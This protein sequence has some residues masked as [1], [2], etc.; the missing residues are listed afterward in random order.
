MIARLRQEAG[1][2]L[3]EVLVAS[4]LMVVVTGA[5]LSVLEGFVRLTGTN[6]ARNDSQE[7]AR[8]ASERLNRELRNLASPTNA[9][10]QAVELAESDDLVFQSVGA[11]RPAGSTNARNTQRVRYCLRPATRE[12]WRAAQTWTGPTAPPLPDTGECPGGWPNATVASPHVTN[13]SGRALWRYNAADREDIT[14][15]RTDLYVD[16]DT[17]RP[18][19][20]TRLQSGVF[21]RNQNRRPTASFTAVLQGG[22]VLLNASDSLDPEG[23]QL[24]YDWTI[25]GTARAAQGVTTRLAVAPGSTHTFALTVTDPAFLS[26]T[27]APR[28]VAVPPAS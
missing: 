1:V 5:S 6:E 23:E 7:Q 26:T 21:L 17:A 28:T 18:P 12:L 9:L 16:A 4:A 11:T 24:T 20:E 27:S 15:I 22:E 8:L 14:A 2:T 19:G 10:P 25:D 3:V 13:G